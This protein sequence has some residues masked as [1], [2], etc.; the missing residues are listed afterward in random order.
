MYYCNIDSLRIRFPKETIDKLKENYLEK[1]QLREQRVSF[2]QKM[3]QEALLTS[4]ARNL[5]PNAREI[6]H[7]A[8]RSCR[9]GFLLRP[10]VQLTP[11]G[12]HTSVIQPAQ[13]AGL[14]EIKKVFDSY[15]RSYHTI[16]S[17]IVQE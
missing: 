9:G 15:S 1:E 3:D 6:M 11:E 16:R 7:F 8:S 2:V 14:N 5:K 13:D 12:T 17:N 10:P 4:N